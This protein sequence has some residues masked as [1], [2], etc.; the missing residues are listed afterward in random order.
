MP[1]KQCVNKYGEFLFPQ[2][3]EPI[4]WKQFFYNEK[5]GKVMGRTR[6]SWGALFVFYSVYFVI[7]FSL[8]AI[9]MQ[10]LF[11]TLS[12]QYPKYQLSDSLIGNNPGL[13]F[14]PMPTHVKQGALIYYT[15]AN[16]SQ[17]TPWVERIEQFLHPYRDPSKLP[18]EGKNQVNCNFTSR[19]APGKVCKVDLSQMGPCNLAD[20]YGYNKS[21]PC[22][23][24]KMNRIYGWVPE[25]YDV[26][27]LPENMPADLVEHIKSL[28][29][30]ERKQV[31]VSCNGISPA[32]KEVIGPLAFYPTRG[33]PG[34]YFP[35]LN[36]PGYL[37][38]VLAVHFMRTAIK[39]SVNLECRMWAKNLVYRGGLNFRMA[40]VS[41]V[42]LVD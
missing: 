42:L 21:T 31:W 23:F 18:L 20:G 3:P 34:Y 24:V 8:F 16:E 13:G 28:P 7:L 17:V 41:I 22:I 29:E 32:D 10:G 1:E 14:R 35:Y 2:R 30:K 26:D 33:F 25:Y 36:T 11:Y 19:P 15:A 27:K 12:D 37:S 6:Y 38:P 9:C 5:T 40:S 39:Q 4:T